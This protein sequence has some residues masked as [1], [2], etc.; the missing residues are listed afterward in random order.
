MLFTE[1]IALAA[2]SVR[3]NKLRSALTLLSISI[4]VFAIMGSTT[5]V[6]SLDSV[7]SDQLSQLGSNTFYVTKMPAFIMSHTD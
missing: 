2:S 5:V 6:G 4:G 7:F 3:T 1:S